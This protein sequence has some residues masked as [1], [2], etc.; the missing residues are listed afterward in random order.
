MLP[1]THAVPTDGMQ[2]ITALAKAR[3][4]GWGGK[5][6]SISLANIIE[7]EINS[8]IWAPRKI[9]SSNCR[10][11]ER[12]G[13]ERSGCAATS[14]AGYHTIGGYF[15]RRP[16]NYCM[17]LSYIIFSFNLGHR[18]R[19]RSDPATVERGHLVAQILDSIA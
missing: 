14:N 18:D 7:S 11:N 6:A 1:T 16:C 8:K 19:M 17:R 13:I 15:S 3:R 12:P 4:A 9:P 10:A 5:A 2:S